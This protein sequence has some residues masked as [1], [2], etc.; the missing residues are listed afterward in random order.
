MRD[1][2]ILRREMESEMLVASYQMLAQEYLDGEDD[3]V[4]I[5]FLCGYALHE[6]FCKELDE[7]W[8]RKEVIE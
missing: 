7:I 6:E 3:K 8:S 4:K 2:D 1:Q 5:T